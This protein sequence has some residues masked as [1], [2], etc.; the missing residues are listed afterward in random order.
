MVWLAWIESARRQRAAGDAEFQP[1]FRLVRFLRITGEND[2]AGPHRQVSEHFRDGALIGG[3]LHVP[4]EVQGGSRARHLGSGRVVRAP[5]LRRTAG[6]PPS[7]QACLHHLIGGVLEERQPLP[8][9]RA[10][11]PGVFRVVGDGDAQP[12]VVSIHVTVRR[13]HDRLDGTTPPLCRE[14]GP[15]APHH[16][17]HRVR[18]PIEHD[19]DHDVGDALGIGP[20]AP[21]VKLVV[22]AARTTRF[23]CLRA[24]RRES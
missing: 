11:V 21:H 17:E 7:P 8:H 20:P 3:C 18:K 16:R 23:R 9:P 1:L 13:A 10:D 12:C 24:H 19:V 14:H 4:D 6:S 5:R 22:N 2:R 15:D